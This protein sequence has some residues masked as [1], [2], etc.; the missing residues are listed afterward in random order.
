MSESV[1]ATLAV[2]GAEQSSY[3]ECATAKRLLVKVERSSSGKSTSTSDITVTLRFTEHEPVANAAIL[4][5]TLT[6]DKKGASLSAGA[7]AQVKPGT[8][9]ATGGRLASGSTYAGTIAPGELQTFRVNVQWGQN[10]GAKAIVLEPK[11][12]VKAELDKREKALT[13]RV[14]SPLGATSAYSYTSSL[15]SGGYT[16]VDTDPVLYRGQDYQMQAGEY[17]VAIGLLVDGDTT[18]ITVPYQVV[19]Q[20]VGA[21]AGVPT[22]GAP[23]SVTTTPTAAT[24]SKAPTSASPS[25]APGPGTRPTTRLWLGLVGALLLGGGIGGWVQLRRVRS[26]RAPVRS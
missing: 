20:A 4:P 3:K 18:G 10:L 17:T 13:L 19:V 11:P 5:E 21:E 6:V 16:S 2:V 22:Y 26:R 14:L 8:T 12:S 15:T 24:T 9:L 25:P 1:I 23:G 7:S